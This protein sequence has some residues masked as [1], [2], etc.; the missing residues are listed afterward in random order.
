MIS[1]PAWSS[2]LGTAVVQETCRGFWLCF[3]E[4]NVMGVHEYGRQSF[5]RASRRRAPREPL[6]ATTGK[7]A[8]QRIGPGVWAR[9]DASSRALFPGYDLSSWNLQIQHGRHSC[10]AV[11]AFS[12]GGLTDIRL[13]LLL[14]R[15]VNRILGTV[16][17]RPLNG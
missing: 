9:S 13:K 16:S 15:Q 5:R 7:H 6:Y 14:T 1:G 17:F 8:S 11:I 10:I 3:E 2:V 4:Y 12:S